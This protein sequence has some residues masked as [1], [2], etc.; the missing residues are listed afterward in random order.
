LWQ[1]FDFN[2]PAPAANQWGLWPNFGQPI[3]TDIST[4]F[5]T[6]PITK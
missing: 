1:Q 4:P 3:R 2:P 5:A 6:I